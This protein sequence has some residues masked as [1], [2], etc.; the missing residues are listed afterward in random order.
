[1]CVT[2]VKGGGRPPVTTVKGGGR[3][4]GMLEEGRVDGVLREGRGNM[5]HGGREF[6]G[7]FFLHNALDV[8]LP[9]QGHVCQ[10]PLERLL[11]L[12]LSEKKV[13]KIIIHTCLWVP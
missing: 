9:L 11:F 4:P 8:L 7:P 2:T 10:G 3:P 13:I 6:E 5:R 12:V 1:M